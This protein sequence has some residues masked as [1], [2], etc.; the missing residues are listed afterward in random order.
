MEILKR[1]SVKV[2]KK[3]S[4]S[5]Q[6]CFGET[7]GKGQSWKKLYKSL[8]NLRVL[9]KKKKEGHIQRLFKEGK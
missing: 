1:V 8:L 3:S 9:A 6:K 7:P 4:E 5:I 2:A